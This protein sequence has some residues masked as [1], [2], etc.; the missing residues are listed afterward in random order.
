[1]K[2][3]R[4]PCAALAL[5]LLAAGCQEDSPPVFGGDA[6]PAAYS[7]RKADLC[8]EFYAYEGGKAGAESTAKASCDSAP[9]KEG[10]CALEGLVGSCAVLSP[11][12]GFPTSLIWASRLRYYAPRTIDEAKDRCIST[13]ALTDIAVRFE[14][15]SSF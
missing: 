15:V 13:S 3:R 11:L 5:L 1:M 12:P 8:R 6:P 10:A 14:V 4:S 9:I 2:I 7:C